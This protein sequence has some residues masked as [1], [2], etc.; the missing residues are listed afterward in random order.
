MSK[1]I[2]FEDVH[3]RKILIN[4]NKILDVCR[5]SFGNAFVTL[6]VGGCEDG[7]YYEI[8]NYEFVKRKIMEGSE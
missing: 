7:Y 4:I 5:N 2:E 6:G 3:N 1:F 8:P